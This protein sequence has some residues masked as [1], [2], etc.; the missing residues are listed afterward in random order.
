MDTKVLRW[1]ILGT[2]RINRALI[3]PLTISPRNR[4][5]AVASR[6][7]ERAQQYARE[8]GI[9][10]AHGSYEALLA[11]PEIDVVYISLPNR[12]H[13][14]WAIKAAKAGKHVLCEKPIAL[15]VEDVDAIAEA[16]AKNGVVIAEAFMYRHHPQTLKVC[17]LIETGTIGRLRLIR[18]GFTYPLGRTGDVRLKPELG[19]GSI[20][21]VGCYPISFARAVSGGLAPEEVFGWQIV[22]PTGVD[23]SF[24]G[25][26]HF[27]NGVFAQFDSGFESALRMI[28]EFV[29][30]EGCITLSNAFKPDDASQLDL[31]RGD[32]PVETLRFADQELY[33]GEVEDLYDAVVF[34]K[35]QRIQL[36]DSRNNVAT[37]LGLLQSAREQTPILLK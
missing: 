5:L 37:I 3:P 15:T 14:E 34:G 23:M 31:Q 1:G 10:R 12:F 28:M 33:L 24:F 35:P 16:G 13:A 17:E 30:S 7:L 18:G 11:D 26:M 32:G 6:E 21:D 25:Q 19:G 8:K 22:G 20:W 4:L 9:E 29:G 27:G 36:S 2:A